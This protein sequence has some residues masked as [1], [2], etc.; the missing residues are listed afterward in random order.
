M[1]SGPDIF[2]LLLLVF[3]IGS[4]FGYKVRQFV[5]EDWKREEDNNGSQQRH[6]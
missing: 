1:I 3:V 6:K 5:V 4:Y 2:F